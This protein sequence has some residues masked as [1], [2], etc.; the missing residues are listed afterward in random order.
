MKA[1]IT[2]GK[3]AQV[4][5]VSRS[6]VYRRARSGILPTTRE[7][8]R[9]MVEVNTVPATRPVLVGA[10]ESAMRPAPI[11]AAPHTGGGQRELV[12]REGAR[13]CFLQGMTWL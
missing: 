2:V 8:G 5:G 3:A 12:P 4:I 7:N 13:I 1:Y 11:R 10:M 6:T 9:I